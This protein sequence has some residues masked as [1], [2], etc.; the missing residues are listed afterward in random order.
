MGNVLTRE[1]LEFIDWLN[2]GIE[3]GARHASELLALEPNAWE[4]WAAGHPGVFSYHAFIELYDAAY[5]LLTSDP[6]RAVAL[7]EFLVRH[8]DA[9]P[10]PHDPLGVSLRGRAWVERSNALRQVLDLDGALDASTRAVAV[11][12]T[13][14]TAEVELAAARRVDAMV[15]HMRGERGEPLRVIREG[16]RVFEQTNAIGHLFR[17]RMYEGALEF[18]E[19][20]YGRAAEIF[21]TALTLSQTLED[22]RLAAGAHLN[23]GNCYEELGRSEEAVAHLVLSLKLFEQYGM[24]AESPRAVW[25][26]AHLL[27]R[28]G[29]VAQAETELKR[30]AA[31]LTAAGMPVEGALVWLD[32]LDLFILL[33]RYDDVRNH[34][35]E[36][37]R[38]FATTGL[39]EE[40]LHAVALLSQASP[41][42]PVS[43][44]Q[45]NEVRVAVRP[46][47]RRS[48]EPS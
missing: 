15:R 33:E 38:I 24:T 43:H 41:D 6:R 12:S 18:A 10:V 5:E 39:R 17:S 20:N 47:M 1:V 13:D 26:L 19:H 11:L 30:V 22:D 8:V 36:L 28:T 27:A 48:I 34:A 31:E 23:L 29:R 42:A 40:A 35:A 37:A 2:R 7:T 3:E 14:P 32:L 44:D 21:S 46:S 4:E 9:V 45:I 25:G 16:M